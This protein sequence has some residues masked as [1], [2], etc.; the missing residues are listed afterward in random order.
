MLPSLIEKLKVI[1]YIKKKIVNAL[2]EYCFA[3]LLERELKE[4]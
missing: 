3:C 2:I 4:E 1:I